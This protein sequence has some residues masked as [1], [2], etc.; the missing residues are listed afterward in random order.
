MLPSCLDLILQDFKHQRIAYDYY[1]NKNYALYVN[2]I[3][4]LKNISINLRFKDGSVFTIS[5]KPQQ[6]SRQITVGTCQLLLYPIDNYGYVS[7]GYTALQAYYV[8]FDFIKYEIYKTE[9]ADN[10]IN[11]F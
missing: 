4:K 8:G 1:P 10:N 11:P 3:Q 9:K 6:Y 5:L 7:I 2:S